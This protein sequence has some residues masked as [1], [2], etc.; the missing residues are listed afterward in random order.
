MSTAKV[1]Q[2]GDY[3]LNDQSKTAAQIAA[4]VGQVMYA[5]DD[6]CKAHGIHLVS[7][8]P[9]QATMRMLVTKTMVNG[10]HLG[11]GGFVF[12]LADSAF[13]YACNSFGQRA[14][15]SS[16]AIEFLAAT[17][18]DDCLE[19]QATMV[20]QGKRSGLYDIKVINQR[21]ET[22]AIFRGRSATIKGSFLE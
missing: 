22:I 20:K 16:A 6:A 17:A 5:Q 12:L 19:A 18:L 2:Y 9:G 10:H 21:L 14:V 4:H 11:H 1:D 13:A 15:A 7:I 8:A 3:Q